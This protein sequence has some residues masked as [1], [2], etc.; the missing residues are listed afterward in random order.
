MRLQI[1]FLPF[2]LCGCADIS[3]VLAPPYVP[4]PIHIYKPLVYEADV[5]ECLAAGAAYNPP[6]SVGSLLA[7]TWDGG[8]ANTSLAPLDPWTVGAGAAGGAAKVLGDDLNILSGVHAIVA[9][10]CLRDETLIDG[11]AVLL[12]DR[13]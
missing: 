13:K 5:N 1:L 6:F 2:L 12:N 4:D 11:S 3:T 8:T 9:R 7:G 10:N